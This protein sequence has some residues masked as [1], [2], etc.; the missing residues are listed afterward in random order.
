MF[1]TKY[2]SIFS[3]NSGSMKV[4]SAR[5][6]VKETIKCQP[7]WWMIFHD[8]DFFMVMM[9]HLISGSDTRRGSMA[10]T[11]GIRPLSRVRDI[12]KN[13]VHG[14][15]WVIVIIITMSPPSTSPST[16]IGQQVT[17]ITV[18]KMIN[19]SILHSLPPHSSSIKSQWIHQ[20]VR[21]YIST[22][23]FGFWFLVNANQFLQKS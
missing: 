16:R 6:L 23:D 9:R 2:C 11:W 22:V 14:Q 7:W 10:G 4:A 5:D 13:R 17:T 3:W 19:R 15:T 8:G 1:S 20:A 21:H 18:L 12:V